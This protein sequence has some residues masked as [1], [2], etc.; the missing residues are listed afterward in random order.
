VALRPSQ[1]LR[2]PTRARFISSMSHATAQTMS[3]LRFFTRPR[4]CDFL[5]VVGMLILLAS[6]IFENR[7]LRHVDNLLAAANEAQAAINQAIQ[8][9]MIGDLG[10]LDAG[11]WHG[12]AAE[13]FDDLEDI[14]FSILLQK[15][16]K[17]AGM[18]H[19]DSDIERLFI[20]R[21][22]HD[23]RF[24]IDTQAFSKLT[25]VIDYYVQNLRETS[26]AS[27]ARFLLLYVVGALISASAAIFRLFSGR[28]S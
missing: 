9:K 18:E 19:D 14:F 22:D 15:T 2:F 8:I 16:H 21:G 27:R 17:I 10:R 28:T 4:V 25:S 5:Q 7:Y 3:I 13:R 24:K 11:F 23:I 12:E 1:F 20:R 6:W 26:A